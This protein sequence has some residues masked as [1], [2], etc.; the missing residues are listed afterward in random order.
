MNPPPFL[1][2]FSNIEQFL[3]VLPDELRLQY[4]DEFALLVSKKLPPIVSIRCLATLLGFSPR[5]LGAILHH[6]ERYY[7]SFSIQKGKKKRMI[8]APKVALK[9]IQ[10]WF[11]HYLAEAVAFDDC[12]Y[13]F[14]KGRSAIKAA[15]MHCGSHWIYSVD[16]K[17]F[18]PMTPKHMVQSALIS[19]GYSEHGAE[20]A[21]KLCCYRGALAQGSPASPVLSNLVFQNVDAKMCALAN[22]YELK[23]TRYADDITFSGQSEAPPQIAQ[24]VRKIIEASGWTISETKEKLMQL[25]NRLKVHGLLVHG[26]APRLTKGYRNRIRA[27]EHLLKIGKIKAADIGK[28]RG[29]LSFADS[30]NGY[31]RN[32]QSE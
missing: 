13:G 1:I 30:V 16:I 2:S 15:S 5:F 18:F 12:V 28:V 19:L 25:P 7:R 24:Q 20:I 14:V 29:H 31:E 22:S 6:P 17:D 10:K 3:R 32:R 9:V 4:Q 26:L 23:Y 8:Q 27:Y 11:G 21:A